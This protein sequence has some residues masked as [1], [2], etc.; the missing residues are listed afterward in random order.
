MVRL[1]STVTA[2]SATGAATH[3]AASSSATK[4]T[5]LVTTRTAAH[6]ATRAA[7]PTLTAGATSHTASHAA[8]R[9][10]EAALLTTEAS[11]AAVMSAHTA[12][13]V[14]AEAAA[15]LLAAEA[16]A[17]TATLLV[18]TEAAAHAALLLHAWA[19]LEVVLGW[20][21]L[22]ETGGW[23]VDCADR[24]LGGRWGGDEPAVALLAE[25]LLA[26]WTSL[27]VVLV[28]LVVDDLLFELVEETHCCGCGFSC[29]F[30]LR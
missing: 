1:P 2:P 8:A 9:A 23:L 25:A 3:A 29:S 22:G 21:L 24:W 16:T 12:T 5:A 17:H 26:V 28:V 13:L 11:T 7:K 6:T 15:L 4:P 19:A 27:L 30:G 10:T 20:A 14:T 18:T